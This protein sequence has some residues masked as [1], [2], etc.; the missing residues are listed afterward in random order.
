[1]INPA[2]VIVKGGAAVVK[3]AKTRKGAAGMAQRVRISDIADELG[4]S[5]A[6]VSNV[7]HGKT[8]RVS[9]ET[10]RRVQA[11]LEEREYIPSMAGVLLA[12]NASRIIGVFVNDH[13]KYEGA[14]LSD[15]FIA[16][17][18]DHLSTQI[19]AHG[20]FMMVKKA[21]DAGEI[22]KFASMWNM[23]G[24]VVIGFCRQD[25]VYLRQHIRLPF[26]V[27]DGFGDSFE[28]I[29][30]LALD[31]FDG[32]RQVGELFKRLGHERVL[33]IADNDSGVDKERADGVCRGLGRECTRIVV[34]MG[35][36][37][38]LEFYEREFA[39]L[40]AATAVFA[41]SD[42]YAAEL[43]AFLAKKG[44]DVPGEMSVAGFDDVP[45]AALCSPP[46]TTVRQDGAL[47][48]KIAIER[49]SALR[50]GASADGTV[51]LPVQLVVRESTARAPARR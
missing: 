25:Y 41:A 38:R 28:R 31:N 6:T 10:V 36:A 9:D 4:L 8:A 51:T 3:W 27:Y 13:E 50:A 40:R 24:L 14:T 11:L 34:P 23:D 44:V 30:N 37:A 47:R 21:K 15:A 42:F 16:A 1:M 45:F 19:E 2:R 46:L 17:T 39:A 12:Q 20:Q 26:A 7:I 43:I 5:T 49:L 48:A 32:G 29:V 22:I 18:L 33:C 35:R